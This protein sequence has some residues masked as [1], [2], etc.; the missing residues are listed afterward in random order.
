MYPFDPAS[1][2]NVL[3][4]DGPAVLGHER[5]HD[6][7]PASAFGVRG[8][9][10]TVARQVSL[11][12]RE[13]RSL[14]SYSALMINGLLQT[15]EYAHEIIRVGLMQ[16]APP[17]EVERRVEVRTTRQSLLHD[18]VPEPLRIW[19]VIDEAVLRR[20]IGP[21]GIMAAQCDHLLDLSQRPNVMIQVLPF[22]AGAHPS[23]TGAFTHMDFPEPH[24]PDI[25]YL[26]GLTGALYVEDE[27]QVHT[28]SLAF[29]Q[30]AMTALGVDESL[31][32]ISDL[33]EQHRKRHI[34][35]NEH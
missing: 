8:R 9:T 30:L 5:V 6:F 24:M 21:P 29:N 14:R 15:E 27:T 1:S 22:E 17:P 4:F 33:A 19:S 34:G 26:D 23:L 16:F 10:S 25:V 28:Y 35:V 3:Q 2:E 31:A 18:R 13:A 32:M 7:Q 11:P 12:R 20:N